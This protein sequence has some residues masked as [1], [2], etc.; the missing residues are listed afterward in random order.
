M[1]DR[2]TRKRLAGVASGGGFMLLSKIIVDP[3]R[4]QFRETPFSERSVNAILAEGFQLSNDPIPVIPSTRGKV[5]VAGDGHSRLEAIRRLALDSRLPKTWKR[6]NECDIPVRQV[7][8][9][10]ARDL[11]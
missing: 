10:E 11:A 3:A 8:C 5:I 2:P 1:P 9:Y 4:F 6:G 7:S